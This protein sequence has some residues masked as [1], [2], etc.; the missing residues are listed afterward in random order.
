M[1]ECKFKEDLRK[2]KKK[3]ENIEYANSLYA[4][5]CN[6]IWVNEKTNEEYSCSWRYSGGLIAYLREKNEDYL[7]FYCNGN[8]GKIRK[9]ILRDLSKLGWK[10]KTHSFDNRKIEIYI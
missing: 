7:H 8:E 9:D 6:I 1:A 2:L 10:P 3:L 4:A 5:L